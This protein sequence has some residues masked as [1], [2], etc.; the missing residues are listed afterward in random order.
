MVARCVPYVGFLEALGAKAWARVCHIKIV[1]HGCTSIRCGVFGNGPPGTQLE[2]TTPRPALPLRC[3][4]AQIRRILQYD[5][6]V[7]GL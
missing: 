7:G 3:V 4:T 5:L 1:R 2:P 6:G